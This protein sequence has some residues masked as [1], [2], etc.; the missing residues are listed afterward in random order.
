MN[1][2]SQQYKRVEVEPITGPTPPSLKGDHG[3]R[4]GKEDL[5]QIKWNPLSQSLP[6]GLWFRVHWHHCRERG[7]GLVNHLLHIGAW[8]S[9]Q[10]VYRGLLLISLG[11]VGLHLYQIS[12]ELLEIINTVDYFILH[13]SVAILCNNN[14][15]E[16]LQGHA[17]LLCWFSDHFVGRLFYYSYQ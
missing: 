7:L 8:R 17:C 14:Q 12:R 1:H 6:A 2:L 13:I 4:L 15:L 16:F 10:S 9:S 5:F 11:R 3:D